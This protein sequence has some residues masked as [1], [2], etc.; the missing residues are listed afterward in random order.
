MHYSTY[1]KY[2]K[3][4]PQFSTRPRNR[5]HPV[6]KAGLFLYG[7]KTS[8]CTFCNISSYTEIETDKKEIII[9]VIQLS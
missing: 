7:L 1:T 3:Q 2:H 5:M 9:R 4:N 6:S 8:A